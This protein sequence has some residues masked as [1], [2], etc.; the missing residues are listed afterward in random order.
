MTNL[1]TKIF[2]PRYEETL[3]QSEARMH[4]LNNLF[5]ESWNFLS[6]H[7]VDEDDLPRIH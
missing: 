7:R 5:C 1:F 6:G 4:K 3:E 2:H